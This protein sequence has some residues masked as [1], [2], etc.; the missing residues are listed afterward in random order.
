MWN[1]SWDEIFR[2]KELVGQE[3]S[4]RERLIYDRDDS[5]MCDLVLS[6]YGHD[7]WK[8]KSLLDATSSPPLIV[9]QKLL[10]FSLLCDNSVTRGYVTW[11]VRVCRDSPD[12]VSGVCCSLLQY[13]QVLQ[14]IALCCSYTWHDSSMCGVAH[15]T[16]SMPWDM[17]PPH[18]MAGPLSPWHMH[19]S[20]DSFICD[21]T[22][23]YVTCRRHLTHRVVSPPYDACACDM[24][25]SYA[26]WRIHLI[27][28]FV[29]L[30]RMM[31]S[32]VI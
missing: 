10:T 25:H 29:P 15:L 16:R 7:V 12:S 26:T 6:S 11:L 24:T 23:S 20:H 9:C 5:S 19:S 13:V 2:M 18:K 4:H 22:N 3:I 21:I 30:P 17:P 8:E 27:T 1:N 32:R 31:H 14:C 28:R